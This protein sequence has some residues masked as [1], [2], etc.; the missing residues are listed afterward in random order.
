M[1][2]SKLDR[3]IRGDRV[4][5]MAAETVKPEP[6]AELM[7]GDIGERFET[8]QNSLDQMAE[9]AEKMR[10]LE[11][12]LGEM[13]QPLADE[14]KS[15]KA[16]Y[17]E[18]INLRASARESGERGEAATLEVRRLT[19]ALADAEGR[20][21]ELEAVRADQTTAAQDA[22]LEIDRLRNALSQ[23]EAHASSLL[24]ADRETAQRIKQMEQDQAEL[25]KQIQE[26]ETFRNEA[27]TGRTRAV[28]DHTL[29]SDENAALKRRM[30]EVATEA[31]RLARVE[32]SLEAQL[33]SER[34]RA[35]GEQ[36][37]AGRAM[38]ALEAQG[39]TARSEASALQVRLDTT[40]ARADR[41][42]LLNVDISTRL[43]ETE[44]AHQVA[45]RRAI[46]LQTLLDRAQDRIRVLDAAAEEARTRHSSMEAARLAAVDRAE[47]LSNTMVGAEKALVRSADRVVK[48]QMQLSALQVEKDSEIQGL[49]EQLGTMRS[50][51][52]GA[53]AE[54]AM[55]A[56]ALDASRRDRMPMMPPRTETASVLHI[57]G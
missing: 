30:E 56:S 57:A 54:A 31:A 42:E 11:P 3:A 37:E 2:L 40:T 15:R 51:L 52:E 14:F 29:A 47:T 6:S 21:E 10:G 33:S 55:A 20:L 12:L 43:S 39:E 50:N 53:R 13:R 9:L 19:A 49:S 46:E 17:L 1:L 35:A 25:R 23:A 22:R 5:P 36:S 48:L 32:A 38:R 28:R 27:E 26:V 16:D 34:A 45:D 18:L 7:A 41:L 24:A 44:R 8:I 4:V